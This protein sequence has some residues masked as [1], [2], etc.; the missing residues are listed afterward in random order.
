[1]YCYRLSDK[2]AA[3]VAEFRRNPIGR[4]S[5]ELQRVLN[6]LRG[7]PRL[8]KYAVVCTRPGREWI[9]AELA[10]GRGQPPKLERRRKF[11]RIEDAEWEVF[12]RRWQR[13]TGI[14]L[15]D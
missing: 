8:G 14:A 9:I 13:A 5:P 11:K 7:D 10:P 2:D 12:K 15:A 1:M 4:H 3:V 6:V